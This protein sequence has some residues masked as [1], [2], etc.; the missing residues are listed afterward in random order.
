M[1]VEILILLISLAALLFS[2]DRLIELIVTFARGL[3]IPT[4][5]VGLTV[6]A[7]GT[8]LPEVMASAAAA[9]KGHPEI[10]VGNVVG[11]NVCNV[12]L[13]LGLPALF[14]PIVCSRRVIVR[15]GGLMLFVTGLFWAIAL[16]NGEI[17]RG[18]SLLFVLGFCAFI[19]GVFR[20]SASMQ[21]AEE[22]VEDTAEIA[23]VG[24]VPI[25]VL[26]MIAF[27]VGLLISSEFLVRST[28]EIARGVGIS[29]AVIAISVIALGTSLPEL[30]VSIAAAKK[31]Q[32]D[33]LV[34]NI[35]GS[36]ISN[37]LLVL[38]VTGLISP[39]PISTVTT[40]F[41]IPLMGTL[42]VAMF[43]F[44]YSEKGISKSRGIALLLL[45][46]VMILRCVA[47]PEAS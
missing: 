8:S 24:S 26:K 47:F 20:A 18:I 44:L 22:A 34:G 9:F 33:I 45:Y 1:L 38:G 41:D 28:I 29:E 2:A 43:A 31:N 15:Q 11:S 4:M 42:A 27:L 37:I 12:G 36:N 40:K 25:L 5:V 21:S 7:I 14:F 19:Y 32:G 13:I 23:D 10:A 16:F 3:N 30:S 17:S 39:F 46:G 6:V 35:L